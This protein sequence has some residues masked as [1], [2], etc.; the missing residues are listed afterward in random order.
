MRVGCP[1][2]GRVGAPRA[3]P[4][5]HQ[6]IRGADAGAAARLAVLETP[7]SRTKLFCQPSASARR[8]TDCPSSVG[9]HWNA[10]QDSRTAASR[11]ADLCSVVQRHWKSTPGLSWPFHFSLSSHLSHP[12]R[13]FHGC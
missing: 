1:G 5:P 10:G 13:F 2:C 4:F 7:W 11:L 3:L 8:Q 12:K 6:S 9:R